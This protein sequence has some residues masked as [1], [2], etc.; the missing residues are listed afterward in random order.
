MLPKLKELLP[1]HGIRYLPYYPLSACRATLSEEI[2]VAFAPWLDGAT[3]VDGLARHISLAKSE[4][5]LCLALRKKYAA[6]L[7]AILATD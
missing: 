1:R 5:S 4:L 2:D 6:G 3:K 7:G